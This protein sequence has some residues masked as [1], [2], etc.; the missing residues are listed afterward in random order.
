M[1]SIVGYRSVYLARTET[2]AMSDA[3]TGIGLRET[4]GGSLLCIVDMNQATVCV[5]GGCIEDLL[6]HRSCPADGHHRSVRCHLSTLL[7]RSPS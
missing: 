5:D 2:V 4:R 7:S 1:L 3:L 6:S